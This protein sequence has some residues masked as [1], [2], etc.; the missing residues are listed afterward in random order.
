MPFRL[1][2]DRLYVILGLGWAFFI[3]SP[4][5]VDSF[6]KVSSV[7]Y[8]T[9][10]LPWLFLLPRMS[11]QL[12][13]DHHLLLGFIAFSCWMWLSMLWA[14]DMSSEVLLKGGR[15]LLHIL[16]ILM[17]TTFILQRCP[18]ALTW[19]AYLLIA[20]AVLHGLYSAFTFYVVNDMPTTRFRAQGALVNELTASNSYAIAALLS[21]TF[22]L[23]K[24]QANGWRIAFALAALVLSS[25][26]VLTISRSTW[27]AMLV[28]TAIL[29]F[30]HPL[31]R[32]YRL[33]L[34]SALIVL[35][36]T[37]VVG[38]QIYWPGFLDNVTGRG[39]SLRPEV[40]HAA[41]TQ[42]QD[43]WLFGHGFNYT[44]QVELAKGSFNHAHNLFL[45]TYRYMGVSGSLALFILLT[46]LCVQLWQQRHHPTSRLVL[47]WLLFGLLTNQINGK[48][49]LARPDWL[50]LSFWVPVAIGLALKHVNPI[51]FSSQQDAHTLH[52]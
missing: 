9:C 40:W 8:I 10:A 7:F 15:H 18:Q 41:L 48:F 2:F 45:D 23:S 5:M 26:V 17:L 12:R 25:L 14:S 30:I 24:S 1:D 44:M 16:C 29:L 31:S 34:G 20:A 33:L 4:F 27:I 21:L 3:A 28:C 36:C 35:I 47:I 11:Q 22:S 51:E 32:K 19:A 37:L 6:G 38:L 13:K 39:T 46:W 42:G 52:N 43:A 50:W 49:P